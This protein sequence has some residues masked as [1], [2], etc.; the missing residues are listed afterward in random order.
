MYR[1]IYI[2][3]DSSHTVCTAALYI[4]NQTLQYFSCNI[5]PAINNAFLSKLMC[6][7]DCGTNKNEALWH[8]I[9]FI[10]RPYILGVYVIAQ[11]H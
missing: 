6:L 4:A 9:Y 7:V 3:L 5:I 2:Y 11:F 8:G 10:K 1:A